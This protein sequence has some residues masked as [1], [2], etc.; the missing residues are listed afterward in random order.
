MAYAKLRARLGGTSVY[1]CSTIPNALPQQR[2]PNEAL[3]YRVHIR[4]V[5]QRVAQA[6]NM[7][8]HHDQ[9][10]WQSSLEKPDTTIVIIVII[11]YRMKA[12]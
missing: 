4:S 5:G 10:D 8:V 9:S 3:V 2:T 7:R 6:I 1:N 11:Y 12:S